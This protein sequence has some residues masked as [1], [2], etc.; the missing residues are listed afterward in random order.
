MRNTLIVKFLLVCCSKILVDFFGY[1]S[2]IKVT[3][4]NSK[5]KE[6]KKKYNSFRRI[7]EHDRR[8]S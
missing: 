6:E 3:M 2:I 7:L 5:K 8:P 1:T 4:M